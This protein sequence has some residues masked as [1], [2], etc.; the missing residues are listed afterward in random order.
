MRLEEKSLM[1]V[2]QIAA[3]KRARTGKTRVKV[4][5]KPTAL[6]PREIKVYK[7]IRLSSIFG[8]VEIYCQ[9]SNRGGWEIFVRFKESFK[10]PA[11]PPKE[12]AEI[13]KKMKQ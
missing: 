7:T 9:P 13:L 6:P 12:G 2:L 4:F 8:E 1:E 11:L 10:N 5:L 3:L